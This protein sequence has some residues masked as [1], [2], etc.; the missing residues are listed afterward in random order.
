MDHADTIPY[1][2]SYALNVF[3]AIGSLSP[4]VVVRYREGGKLASCSYSK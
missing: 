3:V 2:A 1:H 4:L